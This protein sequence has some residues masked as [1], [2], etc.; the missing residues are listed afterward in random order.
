MNMECG[1]KVFH[2]LALN[3]IMRSNPPKFRRAT[4]EILPIKPNQPHPIQ[5]VE[6]F[7]HTGPEE[8]VEVHL[9]LGLVGA[10]GTAVDLGAAF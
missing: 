3:I 2:R 5:L 9:L 4:R 8:L 7:V 6:D 1:T 10:A